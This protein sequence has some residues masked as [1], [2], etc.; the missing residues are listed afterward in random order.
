MTSTQQLSTLRGSNCEV[1]FD[2][3]T[4]QLYAT[5]ASLYQ[6]EPIAVAFP[7][8]AKQAG[9]MIQAAADAD[10]SVTARGAGTGLTGGAIGDGV[11]IDFARY[12]RKIGE[13][14]MER[15][16]VRVG[17]GVVLDQ[18]NR[19]L[20]P[21]GFWFGPDVATSSRATIG[22]MIGNNSSGARTPLYGTTR[23]HLVELEVVLADGSITTVGKGQ[24]N[25]PT[26]Q[27]TVENLVAFN[28]LEITESRPEG[29]L[30]RWPA[31]AIERCLGDGCHLLNL[32]CGSEG[33]LAC[34][35][36]AELKV[37]PLPKERGLCLLFFDS[38]TE[39][40]RAS[41]ELADLEPVAVEHLDRLL[42]D[43]TRGQTEFK[44]ARDLLDLDQ[45]P[46]ESILAVEFFDDCEDKLAE[47][48]R[49]DL[50]TRKLRLTD[51][52]EMNRFWALRKA[53][54]SL[55]T[56]CKGSAKPVTCCE[57]AAVRPGDLPDYVAGFQDILRRLDLEAS[58]Y[59]HA[60]SG[61]LHVR[62]VIDLHTEAGL[63]KMRMVSKEV[64]DLVKQFRG[65]LCAEHG[66]G[67]GRT[68][69]MR[70]QLGERMFRI[71][72]QIKK[73]FDPANLLNPGKIIPTGRYKLTT[74][75]RVKVDQ[76]L[77]LPF[78]P[79]LGF[80][81]KDES[82]IA[83]LEQ[84]NGC[85]GCLK[86]SPTMCP[87]YMV[88]GEEL[89]STRG[90]ANLIRAVL[91]GRG[92]EGV[93]PLRSRELEAA[94]SHCLSCKACTKEC[95][96]NVNMTLLK[97]ELNHARIRRD[98]LKIRERLISSVDALGALGCKA[99]Q[100]ANLLLN[101][102]LTR[103]IFGRA[104]GFAPERRMPRYA[105]K[106]FDEW[107]NA[108]RPSKGWRRGRVI[109][110]DDTFT[111]YH[112]PKV[113]MAAVHVLE[114]A[115]FEVMLHSDRVCCGRPAMSQGHLDEVRRLG[116]QNLAVLNRDVEKTPILFL[117]PSCWS[118]FAEDYRELGLDLAS[119]VAPRCFLFEEFVLEL[120]E[121][122]P[123]ALT[124]NRKPG[125]VAIHAHCHTKAMGRANT[126]LR[127]AEKLPERTVRLLDTGC[128][129][130]AGAF[131]MLA[132]KYELSLKVAEPLADQLRI[133]PFGTSVVATGTSCRHQIKDLT[134]VRLRHIAELLAE[135]LA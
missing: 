102:P 53:G 129:G 82:F 83:N 122:D 23:D 131:G 49:R 76:P 29:L 85:G 80:V 31:Y 20:K 78:E 105:K 42:L 107:F 97:A 121:G 94:L 73:S 18:L 117:E 57:D 90:R 56:G 21:F 103:H 111:R 9:S 119:V 54:L 114:R 45:R 7:R 112:E 13:L 120:I 19:F 124:F 71:M 39:A 133:L 59:G 72:K 33:T 116:L 132:S 50:G 110:W 58:F 108:R 77:T 70:K 96:S 38:I 52:T 15:R 81:A 25:L 8:N 88:T 109:L 99:P 134:N 63:R 12:N 22:G 135:S 4:R 79:V 27:A 89:L 125:S 86:A 11:V 26:Q 17:A 95:P 60:A 41:V 123:E 24:R 28:E 115:G 113:G 16:T 127:L 5:D 69:F 101:S 75:L 64:G 66:V 61:L 46:T 91:Q 35:F 98:G 51:A 55:L 34:V 32:L 65:S 40:M 74:H 128:C 67:I 92:L 118:M 10:V 3:I 130:M 62:P 48:G 68:E 126:L 37:V 1:L 104:L 47:L 36:S 87:T 14:D 93:D 30:K 43:Q 100:F 84:C 2:N 106:R 6:I 44:P